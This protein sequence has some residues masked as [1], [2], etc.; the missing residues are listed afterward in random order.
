[1]RKYSKLLGVGAYVPEKVLSNHDLESMV[2]TSDE[3]IY[4][5]TGIKK[6]H[7]AAED[8]T[9]SS[10]GLNAA[11]KA[12]AKADVQ[13]DSIEMIIV[14][15]CSPDMVFPS[16]ACFLQQKL[17]LPGIPAF[18]VTA[19]CS[20]FVYALSVA[21]QFIR[22][23][24]VKTVLVVGSEIIS[25]ALDWQDRSTC[26]LFGDGAGAMLLQAA[27]E[28]GIYDTVLHANGH[29]IDLLNLPGPYNNEV[30]KGE[31]DSYLQMQGREVFR[32][33]TL[34]LQKTV[35]EL[36]EKNNVSLTEIDW[37]VP[38][39]AN[40]RIITHMAKSLNFPLEKVIMTVDE[41]A[42]TSSAS[43]PLAF[44]AAVRAGKIKRGD[45]VIMEAFGGGLTWGGVLLKF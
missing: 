25:R 13:A 27:D 12:L 16:A 6:R 39:Q 9:S 40:S 30:R 8:E 42:N 34:E 19:A 38:H 7:V 43:V 33:A 37:L 20:G 45:T 29:H 26:V 35:I 18:D 32:H 10:M 22:S 28:P 23:G 21:D 3:W 36:L 17:D 44:D 4:T 2:D 41:H 31:G 1:M 5:R 15:T 11:K 24:Q 14:A